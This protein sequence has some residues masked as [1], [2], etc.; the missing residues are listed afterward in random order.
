MPHVF[1]PTIGLLLSLCIAGAAQA[2]AVN[3]HYSL[4]ASPSRP[5][6][7][8]IVI[9]PAQV[10]VQELSMGG[11]LEKVPEWT[12]QASQAMQ[13]AVTKVATARG[14]F[15]VVPTPALTEEEESTVDEY[16]ANYMVVGLA[17]HSVTNSRGD[18]WAHKRN[19]FDYTL[20]GGLKFIRDKTGAD[21]ALVMVGEDIVSSGGRKAAFVLFAALG[22]GIPLGQSVISLGI[23]DLDSGDILWMHHDFS[24]SKDLKD[25]AATEEMVQTILNAYPGLDAKQPKP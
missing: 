1:R 11:V 23:V 14:A 4:L 18:A 19:H 17:A 8:K 24:V 3:V 12:Q 2:A 10:T 22:V 20:G 25:P 13:T 15:Q 9:L 21:A 6:P 16:L 7:K 5:L